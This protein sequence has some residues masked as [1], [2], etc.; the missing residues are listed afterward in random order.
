MQFKTQGNLLQL[1]DD[2]VKNVTVTN[3][4]TTVNTGNREL[5]EYTFDVNI[6]LEND[7]VMVFFSSNEPIKFDEGTLIKFLMFNKD[8]FENMTFKEFTEFFEN[9]SDSKNKSELKW[10]FLD[11]L[12]AMQE[13]DE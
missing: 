4:T 13:E 5:T 8:Y 7:W 3:V 1:K 2:Y 11:A 10:E 6:E 12:L 9:V